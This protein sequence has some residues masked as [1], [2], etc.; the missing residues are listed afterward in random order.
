MLSFRQYKSS[1]LFLKV[2][3]SQ[4]LLI[5]LPYSGVTQKD[6]KTVSWKDGLFTMQEYD[7]V[8]KYKKAEENL[9]A[10]FFPGGVHAAA[11]HACAVTPVWPTHAKKQAVLDQI[12]CVLRGHPQGANNIVI[13]DGRNCCFHLLCLLPQRSVVPS[14]LWFCPA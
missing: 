14:G 9:V 5:M 1:V 12:T 3:L 2:D 11:L 10:D 6:M 8:V 4:F 7:F 13:C